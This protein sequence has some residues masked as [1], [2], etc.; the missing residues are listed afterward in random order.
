VLRF[1]LMVC[2]ASSIRR[3]SAAWTIFVREVKV[4]SEPETLL[5]VLKNLRPFRKSYPR[6]TMMQPRQNRR[7][8]LECRLPG[9]L[10]PGR[11]VEFPLSFVDG[12]GETPLRLPLSYPANS[13]RRFEETTF[14]RGF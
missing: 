11:V 6:V 12:D 4:A 5:A 8:T 1:R 10:N 7:S 9:D 3:R 2:T 13:I 14:L